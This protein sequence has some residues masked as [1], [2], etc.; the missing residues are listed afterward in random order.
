MVVICFNICRVMCVVH[1]RS[2]HVV[3]RITRAILRGRAGNAGTIVCCVI[4]CGAMLCAGAL[5]AYM[6]LQSLR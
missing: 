1:A 4:G 5:F 3:A 6:D 2:H